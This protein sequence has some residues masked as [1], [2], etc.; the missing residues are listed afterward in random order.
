MCLLGL[1]T[2]FATL[3]SAQQYSLQSSF[4]G[5][6][7]FDNFDF[8][9]TGDPTYGYVHYVDQDVAEQYGMINFSPSDAAV[10]G[11]DT[12]QT[13]DPTA[14]LGRLSIRL[15]SIQSWTHGLFILVRH[16]RLHPSDVICADAT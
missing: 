3:C 2:L 12:T 13:L 4:A 7:F 16:H 1:A 10:W 14:N 11:V 9:T 5:P 6:T 8:W 15:T